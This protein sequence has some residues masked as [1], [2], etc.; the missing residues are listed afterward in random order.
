MAKQ[1]NKARPAQ[2]AQP[3]GQ[4]KAAKSAVG[5]LEMVT[6]RNN[7]YRDNYRKV[8]TALLVALL[9]IIAESFVI[10]FMVTH[11]PQPTYFAT[12]PTGRLTPLQPLNQP[13]LNNRVVFQWASNAAVSVYSFDFV[14]YQKELSQAHADYFTPTGWASLMKAFNDA[15]LIQTVKAKKLT[16]SAVV[17]GAPVLLDQ[18]VVDGRYQWVVQM[19]MLVTY[20]SASETQ[21]YPLVVT[22]VIQRVSTL[23]S[24]R[25]IG[26]TQYLAQ[27]Q[28]STTSGQ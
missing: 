9:V 26:I 13:N 23:N 6:L 28:S 7:F 17:T 16:V 24:A 18:K 2:K 12:D 1:T 4:A 14:N 10:I 8:V 27:Q 21:S 20:Q 25:G 19:P 11:K 15:Q 5:A 3:T 22:M